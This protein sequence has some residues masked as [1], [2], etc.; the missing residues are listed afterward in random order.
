MSGRLKG[1][2]ALITGG[3]SG[4]GLATAKR[5]VEEIGANVYAI[6]GDAADLADLD[7]LFAIVKHRTS[8]LQ[9]A[10]PLVPDGASIVFNASIVSSTGSPAEQGGQ[11]VEN[12]IVNIPLGRPGTTG[13]IAKPRRPKVKRRK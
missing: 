2:T 5:L 8:T 12:S 7:C 3:S 13:E 9:G 1:K 6:R 4:I 11:F 10:L